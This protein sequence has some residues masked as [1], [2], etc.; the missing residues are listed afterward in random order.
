MSELR[1]NTIRR[2]L[3][4]EFHLSDKEISEKLKVSRQTL[5]VW[6]YSGLIRYI[7]TGGKIIFRESDNQVL[8][9]KNLRRVFRQILS[10]MQLSSAIRFLTRFLAACG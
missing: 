2:P 9:E 10:L 7:H 5:Q 6:Q 1:K 4:D 8:L 3:N